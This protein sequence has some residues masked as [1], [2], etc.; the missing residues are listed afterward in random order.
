MLD[1]I[2]ALSNSVEDEAEAEGLHFLHAYFTKNKDGLVVY[3]QRGLKLPE[4]PDGKE[5]R[6]LGAMESNIFTIIGNRMK[7]GRAC[8]S[9]DGGNNLARL[10]TLKHTKMLHKTLDAL[11]NWVLPAKYAEEVIVKMTPRQIP[12]QAGKGYEGRHAA[13][14]PSTSEYKWLRE[15]GKVKPEYDL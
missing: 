4:P 8:W 9:I 5:Y 3:H 15:M 13:S 7:G 1:F 6:R 2:E 10:L 11:M 14:F 12:M